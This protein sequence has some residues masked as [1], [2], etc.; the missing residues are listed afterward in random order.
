VLI[1]TLAQADLIDEYHLHIY[2][3]VLGGGKRLFPDGKRLNLTLVE[4][5]PLPSGV[6]FLRYHC[7]A[8]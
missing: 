6:V 1:H 8:S 3:L 5:A 7:T 2:P 4:S